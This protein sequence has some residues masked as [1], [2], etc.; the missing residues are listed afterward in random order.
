MLPHNI[1]DN[2]IYK[3]VCSACFIFIYFFFV[4]NVHFSVV[5]FWFLYFIYVMYCISCKAK[6]D[7]F[8]FDN[9]ETSF[10]GFYFRN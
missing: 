2:E 10:C 5:W 7:F 8:S 4:E 9:D 1:I 6:I 3:T